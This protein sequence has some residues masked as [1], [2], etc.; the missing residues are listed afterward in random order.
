MKPVRNVELFP[1][2]LKIIKSRNHSVTY[3]VDTSRRHR[4]FLGYWLGFLYGMQYE[5]KKSL[6]PQNILAL[7]EVRLHIDKGWYSHTDKR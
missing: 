7:L 4:G 6:G 5:S 3:A 1:L 2:S